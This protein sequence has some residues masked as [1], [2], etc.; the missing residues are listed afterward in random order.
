[1]PRY[2]AVFFDAG[3]TLIDLRIPEV[4]RLRQVSLQQGRR[5]S[6]EDL[7]H[8][9]EAAHSFFERHYY[10]P[11]DTWSNDAAIRSFW[12]EYYR[13]ALE[14]L[15]WPVDLARSQAG[16]LAAQ[17]DRPE[18]WQPFPEVPD[19]LAGLKGAGY[20]VGILSDWSSRLPAILEALG[21]AAYADFTVVSAIEG[22]AKPRQRFFQLALERAGVS[23]DQALMVGDN[24]YADIQGASR[25]GIPGLLLDRDGRHDGAGFPVIHR[26]DEVWPY[27]G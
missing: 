1:M 25:V 20:R 24:H 10:R 23:A 19:V 3:F 22:V 26:L 5:V 21:L 7:L 18:M 12:T 15:H 4:E 14:A 11:N 17:M 27:L 13:T 8:A 6:D 9:Q 16:H 2:Q